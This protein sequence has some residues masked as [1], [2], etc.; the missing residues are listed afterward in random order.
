MADISSIVDSISNLS[1]G[2]LGEL[3]QSLQDKFDVALP[4]S[5]S[6]I[7]TTPGIQEEQ[8]TEFEVVVV[9]GGSQKINIIKIVRD[10]LGLSLKDS[11]DF[12]DTLPKTLKESVSKEE[13]ENLKKKFEDAGAKVEIK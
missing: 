11:K 1:L 10:V 7:T 12:V 5:I 2:E 8:Q 9:D 6:Q 4:S 13:A 3:K